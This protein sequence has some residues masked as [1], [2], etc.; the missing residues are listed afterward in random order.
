[1]CVNEIFVHESYGKFNKTGKFNYVAL[2]VVTYKIL[3]DN[4]V[5]KSIAVA[6]YIA[7]VAIIHEIATYT[8][9]I[10]IK[11]VLL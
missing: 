9:I 10:T 3:V 11:T 1:M 7:T 5:C 6:M 2:Y 8:A 4:A